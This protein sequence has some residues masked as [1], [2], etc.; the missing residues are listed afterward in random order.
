MSEATDMVTVKEELSS[1]LKS[2]ITIGKKF[3]FE[4]YVLIERNVNESGK[5]TFEDLWNPIFSSAKFILDRIESVNPEVDS[6]IRAA[7][8]YN[9]S[10]A[11]FAKLLEGKASSLEN[12]LAAA[13][14]MSADIG[15]LKIQLLWTE[16]NIKVLYF[17]KL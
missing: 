16:G 3:S 12:F 1:N 11:N 4:K 10:Y 14:F 7:K 15:T 13:K 17:V 9:N 8:E 2:V 5:K 6:V